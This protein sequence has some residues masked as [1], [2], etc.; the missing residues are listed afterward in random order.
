MKIENV[1]AM[2]EA[3]I[4]AIVYKS[5]FEEQVNFES[6]DFDESM[7]AYNDRHAEMTRIY[8]E[9]QHAGPKEFLHNLKKIKEIV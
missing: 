1:K 8:P 9:M 2:E 5:L 3:G 7:T 6:A 4:G